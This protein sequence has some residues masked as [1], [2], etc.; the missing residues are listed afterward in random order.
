MKPLLP[1]LVLATL[2]AVASS[3]GQASLGDETTLLKRPTPP[4]AATASSGPKKPLEA[5]LSSEEKGKSSASST[6]S[7]PTST[8]KV[9][10]HFTDEGATKGEKLR[11]TWIAEAAKGFPKDK[12]LTENAGTLPGP[13]TFGTYYLPVKGLP[14]G[15]YR[16]DLSE[17]DKLAKSIAFTITP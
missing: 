3:R 12:K 15:K 7:F 1:L 8:P 16:M 5:S 14:A 9:Y 11:V 13:G 4:S 6:T 2:A 17:N 10:V